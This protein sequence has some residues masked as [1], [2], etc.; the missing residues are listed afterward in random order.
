MCHSMIYVPELYVSSYS[1]Y[2]KLSA[3]L[4]FR[5][6]KTIDHLRSNLAEKKIPSSESELGIIFIVL[7][8]LRFH[9]F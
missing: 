5:L 7:E 1:V 3:Q 8:Y 6:D 2:S 4:K 9:C